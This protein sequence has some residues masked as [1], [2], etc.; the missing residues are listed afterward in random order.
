MASSAPR[1]TIMQDLTKLLTLSEVAAI[2]GLSPHTIRSFVRQGKLHPLPI[3]R[4]LLF[5]QEDVSN[6]IGRARGAV[7]SI[8]ED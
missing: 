2:L 8:A 4:R 6:L 7:Q 5:D 1:E 3:C